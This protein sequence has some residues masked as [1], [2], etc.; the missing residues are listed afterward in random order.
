VPATV[1]AWKQ[2][3]EDEEIDPRRLAVTEAVG[4]LSRRYRHSGT[5]DEV[6][7]L[8]LCGRPGPISLHPPTVCYQAAGYTQMEGEVLYSVEG[9]GGPLGSLKTMCASREG[10]TPDPLRV[11]W[12]WSDGGPFEAPEGARTRFARSPYLYK[13]YVVRRL[14]RPDEPLA[15]DPAAA[16]LRELLPVLRSC[17]APPP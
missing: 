1:G 17:L 10:V 3:G 8:L 6:S 15:D 7:L 12:G 2:E 16:F 4:Y 11:F 9:P 14:S 13:I 5:G